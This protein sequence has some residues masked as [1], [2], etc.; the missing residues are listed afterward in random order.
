[1]CGTIL[2][3]KPPAATNVRHSNFEN[4]CACIGWRALFARR[5]HISVVGNQHNGEYF[6]QRTFRMLNISN[7]EEQWFALCWKSSLFCFQPWKF[8][9]WMFSDREDASDLISYRPVG[10]QHARM[11]WILNVARMC[12]IS[13]VARQWF[14]LLE[15]FSTWKWRF[16]KDFYFS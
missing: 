7:V 10:D 3:I 16:F 12:W 15:V 9:L 5:A 1:M 6:E 14:S 11:C 2:G 8:V 4:I 13:N